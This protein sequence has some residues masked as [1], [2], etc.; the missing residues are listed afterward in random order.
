MAVL[1]HLCGLLKEIIPSNHFRC[2][3]LFVRVC[4][5][6]GRRFIRRSDISTVDALLMQFCNLFENLFG[7]QNCTMNLHLHLH[8]RDVLH[9]FGPPQHGVSLSSAIMVF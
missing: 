4:N 7:K 3:L 6:I 9:N 1:R 5:I 8:L 2:W